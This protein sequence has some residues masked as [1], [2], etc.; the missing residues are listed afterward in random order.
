MQLQVTVAMYCG[1]QRHASNVLAYLAEP[2]VIVCTMSLDG[3]HTYTSL[4]VLL[5]LTMHRHRPSNCTIILPVLEGCGPLG[6]AMLTAVVGVVRVAVLTA[7]VGFVRVVALTAV[8]GFVR[9]VALMA[10]VGFVRV[11]VL[12]AFFGV[13]RVVV[14]TAVVGVV[15]VAVVTAVAGAT[16]IIGKKPRIRRVK[17]VFVAVNLLL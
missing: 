3:Y 10:I 2:T 15:R 14:L 5:S 7:V 12:M 8:V 9:V 11:A 1:R 6:V 17:I 16:P 13:V 4:I